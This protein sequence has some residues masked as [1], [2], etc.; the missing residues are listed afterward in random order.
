VKFSSAPLAPVYSAPP[1]GWSL[2]LRVE[3]AM[4]RPPSRSARPAC[5]MRKNGSLALTGP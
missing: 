5:W 1:G 2:V 3:M 4:I